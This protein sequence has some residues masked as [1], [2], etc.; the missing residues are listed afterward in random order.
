MLAWLITDTEIPQKLKVGQNARNIGV[1]EDFPIIGWRLGLRNSF[2][3]RWLGY[4]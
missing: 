1:H 3:D 2:L 4:V